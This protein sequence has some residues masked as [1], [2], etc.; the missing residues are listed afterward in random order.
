M[1]RKIAALLALLW[2]TAAAGFAEASYTYYGTMMV[3]HCQE[4]VSLREAPGTTANRLA[5]VPMYAIVTDAEWTPAC[6][7]FIYCN[8]DG[9]YGYILS[10]YLEPWADPEPEGQLVLA[11]SLN[12]SRVVAERAYLNDGEYVL[13][14]CEDAKGNQKWFYETM[15]DSVTELTQTD[16]FLGGTAADPMVMVFNAQKGLTALD[17][18]TGDVRWTL[19]DA[20]VNLGASISHAVG[21]DGTM[22]IGGYYGPDP[23]AIDANGGVRWRSDSEG[24]Y[25]LYRVQLEG[26]RLRCWYDVMDGNHDKEGQVLFDL[27]GKLVEKAY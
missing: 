11:V 20:D 19:S 9:Q 22:Y 3:D 26:S 21:A 13:V 10:E 1:R 14:T 17:A 18:D 12:G 5:E 15:T 7:G 16:A 6:G 24:C 25:W 8:Y 27:N 4:W 23:V 2:L